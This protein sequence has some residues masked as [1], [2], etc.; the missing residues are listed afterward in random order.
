MNGKI[1][2]VMACSCVLALADRSSESFADGQGLFNRRLG[3][4][5]HWGIYSV[6][7]YNVI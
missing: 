1:L 7:G 6:N 2:T 5:V 4:F 3:M